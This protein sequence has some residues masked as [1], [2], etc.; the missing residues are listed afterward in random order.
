MRGMRSARAALVVGLALGGVP[1]AAQVAAAGR[2]TSPGPSPVHVGQPAD[3]GARIVKVDTLAPRM[4]DLTIESPAVGRV[5]VRLLLPS[6]FETQPATSWPVLYL[7]HGAG[8]SHAEWTDNTDVQAVTAPTDLLVVMPDGGSDDNGTAGWYTD[9]YNDGNHGAPAWETFH[10]TELP[11][12]LERNWQAGDRR[13]VAGLSMGGY[14]AMLYAAHH[15]GAFQAAASYSG[16]LDIKVNPD[17]FSDPTAIKRWG[18]PVD[19]AG[20]LG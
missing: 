16:V 15:P 7:L 12:L 8:G 5:M 10:M 13:A 18:D 6:T 17:D 2:V 20:E 4:R 9:W 14:G 19:Q 11:Q 1:A 3:D